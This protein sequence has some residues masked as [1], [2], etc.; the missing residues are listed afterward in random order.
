[1]AHITSRLNNPSIR[2]LTVSTA[3]GVCSVPHPALFASFATNMVEHL[4]LEV[5]PPDPSMLETLQARLLDTQLDHSQRQKAL[6]DLESSIRSGSYSWNTD[7]IRGAVD[8]AVSDPDPATRK[9]VWGGLSNVRR[10]DLVQ[11]LI[12]ALQTEPDDGVRL[13]VLRILAEDFAAD[14]K[15]HAAMEAVARGGPTQMMRM[16][17]QRVL[18]GDGVWH[19]YLVRTLKDSSLTYAQ[20]FE[21]LLYTY[22][23][24]T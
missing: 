16:A 12:D 18:L 2:T 10:S 3:S 9:S 15:V 13:E 4:R 20:R 7:I 1:M 24:R 21:P 17:A 22:R 19:E 23:F 8:L 5:F 6:A 11:P 14:P